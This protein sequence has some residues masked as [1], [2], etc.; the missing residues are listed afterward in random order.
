MKRIVII[1]FLLGAGLCNAAII[2]VPDDSATIQ[3]GINGAVNGD[4]VLVATG[5]YTGDGNRDLDFD[6]R[7]ITVI[8]EYGP[9]STII[10]CQASP[11]NRHRAFIFQNGEDTFAIVKGFTISSGVAPLTNDGG[12]GGGGV[13]CDNSSP[14][15]RNCIF[16]LNDGVERGGGAYCN[17]SSPV[18]YSCVFDTNGGSY[19]GGI[20]CD[21]GNVTI[22][23]CTFNYN[24][25]DNVG[26]GIYLNISNAI[27]TGCDF[28][29]N[30]GSNFGGAIY[31][32]MCDPIITE[33]TFS[34]NSA[35]FCGGAI[36]GFAFRP[37]IT[38][39]TFDY[40][41]AF[42]GGAIYCDGGIDSADDPDRSQVMATITDCVFSNNSTSMAVGGTGG[43]IWW[44]WDGVILLI[45]ESVFYGNMAEYGGALAVG[46]Y[47]SLSMSNCTVVD[48]TAQY[49]AGLA[50]YPMA[51]LH[52]IENSIIAFNQGGSA[53][54]CDPETDVALVCCDVY[55]NAG[56]DY[57]QC[58]E[59]FEGINGNFS[60]DPVFCDRENHDYTLWERLSPCLP[61]NNECEVLIGALGAG[62][63][64]YVC[65][66]ANSDAHVGV[67]D[68][69]YIIN[70][71]FAGGNPPDPYESGDVNCDGY[72]NVAD[73]VWI[74]N[75]VFA[76]GNAP[77]DTDGDGIPD[78]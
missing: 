30:I 60:A 42:D 9:D 20:C 76:G 50:L 22:M 3:A 48:N 13:Y 19:G 31:S 16:R 40:N 12:Y 41:Y 7:L 1:A 75:Y 34:D 32:Q 33:C 4:T 55:G 74:I 14:T 62:C 67:S 24:I 45:Q 54:Y 15:F 2:K 63:T 17:N 39:C 43:A 65:G 49:G 71:I 73:A 77:C 35:G 78:C 64:G 58:F 36:Y 11:A 8:S 27:I 52:L 61:E 37:E 47:L 18:F 68:A 66:D 29:L 51:A 56:G 70:Y 10:N 21:S 46:E 26:G 44:R 25:S 6:G 5:I 53:G 57:V 59:G 72:V 69:I 23:E 38:G 28:M